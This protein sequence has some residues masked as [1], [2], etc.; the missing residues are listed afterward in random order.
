[1]GHTGQLPAP[2][3]ADYRQTGSGI[4]RHASLATP[5]INTQ[6]AVVRP[7]LP[8][9]HHAAPALRALPPASRPPTGIH[10]STA[11]WRPLLAI[12]IAV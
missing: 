1:M 5:Q 12:S 7:H 11:R 9:P 4:H 6:I 10:P 2:H 3:H 8:P